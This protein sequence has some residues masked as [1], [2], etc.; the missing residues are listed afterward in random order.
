MGRRRPAM[1][2]P[3]PA[4][5]AAETANN[6]LR[7]RRRRGRLAE[8]SQSRRG[9]GSPGRRRRGGSPPGRGVTALMYACQQGDVD[10]VRRILKAQVSQFALF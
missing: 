7:T 3:T 8:D 6:F 10:K 4:S 9:R 2:S 5:P 1:N